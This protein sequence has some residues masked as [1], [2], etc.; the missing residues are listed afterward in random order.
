MKIKKLVRAIIISLLTI[1]FVKAQTIEDEINKLSGNFS[2]EWTSFKKDNAGNIVKTTSWKDTVTTSK[3]IVNDTIIYVDVLSKMIFN[4]LHIPEYIVKFKEGLYIKDNIILKHFF[5]YK[6]IEVAQ[7]KLDND[8]YVYSQKVEDQEFPQMGFNSATEG[9]H[10]MV[11]VIIN[12]D[13]QE[14]HKIKRITTILWKD[15][16]NKIQSSQFV[17]LS[18]YHKKI[19]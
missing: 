8:T 19:N 10:T 7:I 16:N 9:I 14:I 6:N 5:T 11:K 15:E 2:G 17:S 12:I 18:G 4:N 1:C 13:G 3:P